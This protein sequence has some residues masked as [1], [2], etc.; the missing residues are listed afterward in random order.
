MSLHYD[1]LRHEPTAASRDAGMPSQ[2]VNFPKLPPELRTMVWEYSLP[3]GRVYEVLDA[4]HAKAKTPAQ[5]GLMFANVHPEPPPALAA[6][7]RESRYIALHRYKPLTLGKTTKFVDLSRDMLLLEPY[8][9]VKRLHRTLQFMSQIPLVRDN[10][11]RLAMG[12]SY[13]VYTGIC[14]PVLNWKVS[15]S[16]M[17]KLV[18]RLADFP[19]LKALV[20]VVH[21]E[22][23]FEFDFA[24]HS[25]FNGYNPHN[26]HLQ[27]QQYHYQQAATGPT[28]QAQM[29][30]P[31]QTLHS[32]A[33]PTAPLYNMPS[34]NMMAPS[35][36]QVI[37]QAYR[38]K[39]DIE[40]NI[41]QHPHR[42]HLNEVLFYPLDV[43]EDKDD[44]WDLN[45]AMAVGEDASAWCLDDP[46]PTNDDYRRFRKRF[47]R[48]VGLA[49]ELDLVDGKRPKVIPALQGASL[50][51]RYTK[52]RYS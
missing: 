41:N 14:H 25:N 39:F 21:Q 11:S 2:F 37:H 44:T 33:T 35:Q 28:M 27:M 45:A 42:P 38:F 46:W 47:A 19:S 12:T 23:Q 1:P 43:D 48:A 5:E 9:L 30:Q 24:R 3:E 20:F 50:L 36:P 8:L 40:A 49:L 18:A 34:A 52:G 10:L 16:N 26:P 13:G 17:G 4:P 6:A 29:S 22:F 51:W 15:K 31:P 7:C 32:A